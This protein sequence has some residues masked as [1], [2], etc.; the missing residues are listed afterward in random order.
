MD[1]NNN[2]NHSFLEN[3]VE[4]KL[5]EKLNNTEDK[6]EKLL[7][8][9]IPN[10]R[11]LVKYI[12]N[13]KKNKMSLVNIVKELKPF[14]INNDDISYPEYNEMR[15]LIK[16]ELL[17]K[18]NIIRK[19]RIRDLNSYSDLI[20]NNSNSVINN[21]GQLFFGNSDM[22]DKFI[23][24]YSIKNQEISSSELLSI[25]TEKDGLRLFTSMISNLKVEELNT[26][27]DL[28]KLFEP[29]NLDDFTNL[30]KINS[31]DCTRRYLAKEYTNI[32]ELE[33]D[34]YKDDVY[35]DEK[36]DDTPYEIL[37]QYENKQKSMDGELFKEYLIENL[38]QKHILDD[39]L[40]HIQFEIFQAFYQ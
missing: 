19:Q 22:Y 14:L 36:Y 12:L 20:K 30:E 17:P 32:T 29:A 4:Y 7:N 33:N 38:F 15:Y 5:D 23:N 35:F 18:F 21:V 10:K 37:K 24:G 9:I 27:E 39:L 3:I 40:Q 16:E 8:V 28:L 25:L 2:E 31:N 11:F 34:Q 1:Y 6:L 26:P 13:H